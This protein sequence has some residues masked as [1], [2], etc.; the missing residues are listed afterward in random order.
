MIKQIGKITL[1]VFGFIG[2]IVS[3][4]GVVNKFISP[5]NFVLLILVVFLAISGIFFIAQNDKTEEVPESPKNR[6]TIGYS[7]VAL[8]IL[9]IFLVVL[10]PFSKK[11]SIKPE[12][13]FQNSRVGI[14][15]SK[16]SNSE[17]NFSRYVLARLDEKPI[18]DSVYTLKRVDKYYHDVI[19]EKGFHNYLDSLC[20]DTGLVVSGIW[21]PTERLF[22]TRILFENF[23][24]KKVISE[25]FVNGIFPI[26]NPNIQEFSIDK[27]A[28]ILADFIYALLCYYEGDLNEAE[29]LFTACL[30]QNQNPNNR[31]F[32][33]LNHTLRG[34]SRIDSNIEEAIPDFERALA[35]NDYN[36]ASFR[37]LTISYFVT[38]KYAQLDSLLKKYADRN[39]FIQDS[40]V[41][42]IQALIPK[43]STIAE[44]ESAEK[45]EENSF[46]EKETPTIT[47]S[48]VV[49]DKM[50][51]LL[52][53]E[54]K[55]NEDANQ[56]NETD[57]N[58]VFLVVEEQASFPGGPPAWT[59][60][61]KRNLKYPR[62]ATR[63]GIEGKVFLSFIVD[64]Q[65]SISDIQVVRGIGGGCDEEAKRVVANSPKWS[66]GKTRNKPVKSRMQ[67][68]IVFR[69]K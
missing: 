31:T 45:I 6:K 36:I 66:P 47:N 1:A 2:V 56:T 52:I 22:Y 18:S 61:L 21:N 68:Q 23:E 50:D 27:Q 19:S 65:G 32:L 24:P 28:E 8:C 10:N 9:L 43:K 48:S 17:D 46:V 67:V 37:N 39:E 16:F 40:V 35:L 30:E 58:T 29:R 7:L 51:T 42:K 69:L 5:I 60:Y 15:I 41:L 3:I 26:L 20:L 12:C 13:F 44:D 33:S 34:I 55:S 49:S 64:K 14:A 62:Q 25:K 53:K 59:K 54:N 38:S 57:N 63:M 11:P 4:Y